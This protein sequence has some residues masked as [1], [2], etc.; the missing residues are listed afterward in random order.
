MIKQQFLK[1]KEKSG[2]LKK[3]GR[4]SVDWILSG[5]LNVKNKPR[6]GTF[7]GGDYKIPPA[8]NNT[9]RERERVES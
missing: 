5:R 2:A 7:L 1:K 3:S 8:L 6:L 9:E 4:L